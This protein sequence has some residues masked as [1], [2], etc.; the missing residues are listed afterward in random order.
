[1]IVTA[2]GV[3]AGVGVTVLIFLWNKLDKRFDELK[4][5]PGRLEAKMDRLFEACLSKLP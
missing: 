1:M 3:W 2:L 4:D 5:G